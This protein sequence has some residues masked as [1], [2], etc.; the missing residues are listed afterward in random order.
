MTVEVVVAAVAALASLGAGLFKQFSVHKSQKSD[1]VI[2]TV[3]RGERRIEKEAI[4]RPEES[5]RVLDMVQDVAPG[6][7]PHASLK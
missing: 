7:Q 1:H 3:Q 5:S 2:V 6:I 4:M